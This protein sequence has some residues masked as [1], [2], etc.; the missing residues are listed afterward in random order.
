VVGHYERNASVLDLKPTQNELGCSFYSV[1]NTLFGTA[2]GSFAHLGAVQH[3]RVRETPSLDSV[4]L[5]SYK[6]DKRTEEDYPFT[7]D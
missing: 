5:P 2:F 6:W 7:L 3:A 1:S 4:Q